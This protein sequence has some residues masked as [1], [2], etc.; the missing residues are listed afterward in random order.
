MKRVLKTIIKDSNL[1][2]IE[3]KKKFKKTDMITWK[4]HCFKEQ[5]QRLERKAKRRKSS[6]RRRVKS[7]LIRVLW[8]VIGKI[9]SG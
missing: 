9:L 3:I 5:T 6:K 7:Q 4:Q 1:S 8:K 2:Q